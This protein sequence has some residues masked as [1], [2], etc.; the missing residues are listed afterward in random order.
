MQIKYWKNFSK[1]RNS[2]K[3]PSGG[4][5]LDVILQEPCS[6]EGPSF[7]L[8]IIDTT[9]NYVQAFG[10]YYYVT[11]KTILDRNR[12]RIDCAM[13]ELASARSDIL[14][15]SAFIER[16]TVLY[17][18]LIID[19]LVST[20]GVT[21]CAIKTASETSPFADQSAGYYVLGT[22][23][24]ENS[25]S[26]GMC[27]YYV[28]TESDLKSLRV[29]LTGNVTNIQNWAEKMFGHVF[30]CIVSCKFIPLKVSMST[31]NAE[32]K[33]GTVSTGVNVARFSGNT[34]VGASS[35]FTI[36]DA[37]LATFRKLDP[38]AS[39]KLFLP[40]YGIINIPGSCISST[41]KVEYSFDVVTG[42]VYA[43]VFTINASIANMVA[44]VQY[45]VGIDVPIA[46]LRTM[47]PNALN[48]IISGSTALTGAMT[49]NPL[50]VGASIA[51]GSM[52][53]ISGIADQAI[54]VKGGMGGRSMTGNAEPLLYI[55]TLGTTDTETT[56]LKT[57]YGKPY[58]EV[59]TLSQASGGYVK[60]RNASISTHLTPDE[61]NAINVALDSGIYL[62]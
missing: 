58:M 15:G 53:I 26:P 18:D 12:M 41:L 46:Q 20:D 33:L 4:T 2:T 5:S 17:N 23:N 29:Y 35:T 21:S 40:N 30:D 42:E 62:E 57:Y 25:N 22:I 11:N 48:G 34:V 43:Q 16:S 38:Y 39:F 59:N 54:S 14:S 7:I 55:N 6:V 47:T 37:N 49:G 10:S 51:S 60:T 45:N 27:M 13:D 44:S 36:P 24:D 61:T 32:I 50:L 9:I 56:L 28:L 31:T 52:G 19:P 8:S 1:R 3:Q